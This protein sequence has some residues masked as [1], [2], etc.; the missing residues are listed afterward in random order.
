MSVVQNLE[1]TVLGM[2][3]WTV[4]ACIAVPLMGAVLALREGGR[5]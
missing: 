3:G 4:V 2:L 1:H 5:R